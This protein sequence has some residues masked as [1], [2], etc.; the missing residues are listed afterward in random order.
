MPDVTG[1]VT[2][3]EREEE[4]IKRQLN[5]ERMKLE[6]QTRKQRMEMIQKREAKLQILAIKQQYKHNRTLL[7]A[8]LSKQ[9]E[10]LSRLRNLDYYARRKEMKKVMH[11]VWI[12]LTYV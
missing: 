6:E 4:E 5:L 11:H 1:E 3:A 8:K 9:Q 12:L 2:E 7:Q 10:F